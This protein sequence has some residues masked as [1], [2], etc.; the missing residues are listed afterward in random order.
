MVFSGMVNLLFFMF[1]LFVSSFERKL[2]S[3][4]NVQKHTRANT[5][6]RE[7]WKDKFVDQIQVVGYLHRW[8]PDDVNAAGKKRRRRLFPSAAAAD[9]KGDVSSEYTSLNGDDA[10]SCR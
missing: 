5:R 9:D 10:G 7:Q 8:N 4:C 3:R 2:F 6:A 1:F